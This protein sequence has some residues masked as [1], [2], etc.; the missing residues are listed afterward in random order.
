MP[1][2]AKTTLI[3]TAAVAATGLLLTALTGK[4]D[5]HGATRLTRPM[6]IGEA[7]WGQPQLVELGEAPYGPGRIAAILPE[8]REPGA[9]LGQSFEKEYAGWSAS[10]LEARSASLRE[11]FFE[12]L[13]HEA[14]ALFEAGH[15]FSYYEDDG[16]RTHREENGIRAVRKSPL[17]PYE[18]VVFDPEE[19]SELYRIHAEIAW[20]DLTTG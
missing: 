1:I 5:V 6:D 4:S 18:E 13:Q 17:G 8:S 2:P 12:L 7:T 15:F 10:T 20:L 16:W 11:R 3:A 14:E 19:T 9:G